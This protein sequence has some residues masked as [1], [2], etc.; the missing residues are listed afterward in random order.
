[1][2]PTGNLAGVTLRLWNG[3]LP[4]PMEA[5]KAMAPP[6]VPGFNESDGRIQSEYRGGAETVVIGLYGPWDFPSGKPR[7]PCVS[8]A[9]CS[10]VRVGRRLGSRLIRRRATRVGI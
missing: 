5:A 9:V 8:P 6:R 2:T 10:A 3:E 7:S 1:M 4:A